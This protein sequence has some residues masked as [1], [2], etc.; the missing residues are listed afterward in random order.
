MDMYSKMT[1][2]IAT[3]ATPNQKRFFW[4]TVQVLNLL[5]SKFDAAFD[6][7]VDNLNA[8]TL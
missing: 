4:P 2:I 5:I 6:S 8:D 7:A 1:T 3:S